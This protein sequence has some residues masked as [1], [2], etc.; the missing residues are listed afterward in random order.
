MNRQVDAFI[1]APTAGTEKQIIAL[2]KRNVPFVLID[3]YFPD[4]DTDNVRINN[5]EAA[6][7]AVRHLIENGRRRI[8]MMAY[9]TGLPHMQERK[10]GYKSALKSGGI[11]FRQEWLNEASYQ[12]IIADTDQIMDKLL[13]PLQVDA[14]FFATNSLAVAGLKKITA[15]GVKV[16][17]QLAVISFDESDAFDFFYSPVTYVSQSVADIGKEAVK[18]V[19]DRIMDNG[20][21]HSSIVVKAKLVVRKSS[22]GKKR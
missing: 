5:F 10:N 13:K 16:P 3:R 12:N 15:L 22:G 1:I 19:I 18:L 11:R 8:A 20:K 9:D 4:L 2:Q 7:T 21:S 6:A 14:F 17:D